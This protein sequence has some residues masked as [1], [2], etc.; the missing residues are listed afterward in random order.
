M[1]RTLRR[2]LTTLAALAALAAV[3][4]TLAVGV[5]GCGDGQHAPTHVH[6]PAPGI[7]TAPGAPTTPGA[8]P[9]TG[10]DTTAAA[11]AT[12][13][14]IGDAPGQFASCTSSDPSCCAARTAHCDLAEMRGYFDDPLF[15]KLI[16]PSSAH[17]VQDVRLFV[18]Y[19]AVQGWNG[20]TSAPGCVY[21]R[22]RDQTWYDLANGWHSAGESIDDLIA[23]VIEARA[24]GL[25]P[26]VT[27]DGYPFQTARPSWDDSIPD[28]T[29][30]A[31]Y[32]AYRC[33]VQGILAELS[34]LPA[35]EQPHVWEALNEPEAFA[36]FRGSAG[37]PASQCDVGAAPQPDG[38]AKA[39]CDEAI[40]GAAIHGFAGHGD[41]TVIA[42]TFQHPDVNYLAP[43][44]TELARVMP[45]PEFPSVWSVHDYREVTDA[46]ADAD[47]T[48]LAAF[49]Q[50]LA[51]DTG[52]RARSLWITEAATVLTSTV[53]GGD[54][55][56]VGVDAAGSL[57]ACI[58]GHPARQAAG[59]AAFFALPDAASAV[60]ITHLFWYE[61]TGAPNWDSGLVDP[62]GNPR[63]AYCVFYGSGHCSGSP[64]AA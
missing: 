24:D 54:C 28:P 8:P 21:S 17:R 38:P 42:G 1:I 11:A 41:D 40:A 39:A 3:A 32:W 33:G 43:Y 59:A 2:R 12:T 18:P 6:A 44:V 4:V 50:A 26:V 57:G 51:R 61:F 25:E 64:D 48:E 34:R 30:T 10:S 20:S 29:T 14:G 47:A 19:D 16:T 56:A 7:A 49:D 53:R 23:G 62:A 35:W 31:G 45:G 60:P 46:Y 58:N 13:Y 55:P 9:T 27:I 52:G 22:V 15:L 5:S 36:I 63:A 37:A